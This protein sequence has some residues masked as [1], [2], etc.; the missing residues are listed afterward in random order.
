MESKERYFPAVTVCNMSPFKKSALMEVDELA[1][2]VTRLLPGLSPQLHI[3]D[4]RL[5]VRRAKGE[6]WAQCNLLASS[7]GASFDSLHS[8]VISQCMLAGKKVESAY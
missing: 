8:K 6:G 4:L 7:P 5:R 1:A 3:S 2:L